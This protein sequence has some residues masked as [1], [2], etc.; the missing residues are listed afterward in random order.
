MSHDAN[1]VH[2]AVSVVVV[3]VLGEVKVRED[4][5]SGGVELGTQ[6]NVHRRAVGDSVEEV[7]PGFSF[8]GRQ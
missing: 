8:D 5:V 2:T 1:V 7:E 3:S 4:G 6:L